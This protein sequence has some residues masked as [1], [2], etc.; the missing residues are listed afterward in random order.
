MGLQ[1]VRHNWAT[2]L[3]WTDLKDTRKIQGIEIIRYCTVGVG[4]RFRRVSC[5]IIWNLHSINNRV[6]GLSDGAHTYFPLLFSCTA[7]NIGA[8]FQFFL[9]LFMLM[10]K[11][12]I[13][14]KVFWSYKRVVHFCLHSILC[15][16]RDYKALRKNNWNLFSFKIQHCWQG[17]DLKWLS[18]RPQHCGKWIK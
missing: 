13:F 6:K 5:V 2:E 11:I 10:E 8:I 12:F 9:N 15:L 7:V 4:K 14:L 17:L 16:E 18:K 1:R 3:N